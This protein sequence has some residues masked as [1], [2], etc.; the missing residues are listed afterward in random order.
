MQN[1]AEDK[2]LAKFGKEMGWLYECQVH[3]ELHQRREMAVVS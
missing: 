1:I 3:S 2:D